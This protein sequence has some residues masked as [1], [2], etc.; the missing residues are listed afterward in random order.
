MGYNM[1]GFS[2][3]GNSPAKSGLGQKHK[4]DS[5]KNWESEINEMVKKP[6]WN[7]G[8]NEEETNADPTWKAKIQNPKYQELLS[9]KMKPIME[10]Y[11]DTTGQ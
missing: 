2:G 5:D 8:R 9:K 3:F 7:K 1:N 4:S 6:N 10:K 11:P